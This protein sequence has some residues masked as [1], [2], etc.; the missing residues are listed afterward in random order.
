MKIV[1]FGAGGIGGYFGARLADAGSEV[2]FIARGAHLTAIRE[3]GLRV[4]SELGD[5]D[6]NPALATDTPD[7]V[8]VADVVMLMV[9]L[10]DTEN[11]ARVMAPMVGKKTTVV[12]FQ[13]GVTASDVLADAFGIKRVIGG[14]TNIGVKIGEPGQ[15]V[16]TGTMAKITFG[17]LNGRLKKRT[18]SLLAV[19]EKAGLDVE[20]SNEITAALW[21]KFIFLSTMSGI[22]SLYRQ[23]IGPIRDDPEKWQEFR[24]A[25]EE[26]YTVA[27]ARGVALA[28][29]L[30]EQR[31]EFVLG[32]P[33]EMNSS[34]CFDLMTGR[35]LE[36]P[37]LSGAVADMGRQ[38]AVATPIHDEFVAA[39]T[40][41]IG[42]D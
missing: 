27:I 33:A 12:S 31:L 18:K 32:L 3:N 39:L 9:K 37:W 4:Q 40:P 28:P 14:T 19:F 15:I 29:D 10:Y 35:R 20:L 25:M 16:H 24:H 30:L 7:D 13:N 8:G 26:A 1:I 23:P 11:A 2:H 17:E 42:G 38:L 36:L 6:I 41:F 34:M 22:T 21:S 5:L